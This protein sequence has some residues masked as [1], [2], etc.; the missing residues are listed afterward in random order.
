MAGSIPVTVVILTRNEAV[1]LP[2]CLAPLAPFGQVVVVDSAST[3]DTAVIASTWGAEVV[4]F[5]W[6]Q[7]A[8]KKKQW[9]LEN[10]TFRHDWVFYVDAD[11]RLSAKL[12]AEIAILFSIGPV[13][14]GYFIV[15][16]PVFLGRAL[17]FGQHNLKLALFDRRHGAFPPCPDL[18]VTTMWEV[19]GHYQPRIAGSVGRLRHALL[20]ADDKGLYA[21]V[22]RHNRYSDWEAALRADGRLA[23]LAGYEGRSRR[24]AKLCFNRLPGRPLLAFVYSYL[25]RLGFLDGRAGLHYALSRAFYYWLVGAKSLDKRK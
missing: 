21:W 3:D 2:A 22:E 19:E 7:R 9:C 25:W 17:R 4:R 1:N 11:E 16:E 15:G 8:P 14:H 13:C 10:L 5:E 6:N 20:H 24:W 18:D 23:A 12:V